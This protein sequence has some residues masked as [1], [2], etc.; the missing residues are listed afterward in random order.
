[1]Q[2]LPQPQPGGPC[3]KQLLRIAQ[4]YSGGNGRIAR[5]LLSLWSSDSF[6]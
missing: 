6:L 2:A 1:M 4:G 5:V 3:L